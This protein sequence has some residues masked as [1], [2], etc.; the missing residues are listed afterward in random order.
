MSDI[1]I[2]ETAWE[3]LF[4]KIMPL[5][6]LV[7]HYFALMRAF[8]LRVYGFLNCSSSDWFFVAFK[9]LNLCAVFVSLIFAFIITSHND[10]T[11]QSVHWAYSCCTMS[12][13]EHP[14]AGITYHAD[15]TGPV[16]RSV[17]NKNYWATILCTAVQCSAVETNT[18]S[19]RAVER[20]LQAWSASLKLLRV[21]DWAWVLQRR[22]KPTRSSAPERANARLS[23][24][25]YSA[26]T[27]PPQN[28]LRVRATSQ[29][30]WKICVLDLIVSFVHC[31]IKC[32]LCRH[33]QQILRAFLS[34][35]PQK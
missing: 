35:W 24:L 27:A 15:Q 16:R 5:K 3:I 34:A 13:T 20:Q 7:A 31:S 29:V 4:Q 26:A 19:C 22:P 14:S 17:C 33:T 30:Y 25:C 8:Q 23:R 28:S 9:I 1:N 10:S 2:F 32:A 12:K 21:T 18:Y 6:G 11:M